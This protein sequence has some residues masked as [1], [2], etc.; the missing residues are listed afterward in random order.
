MSGSRLWKFKFA[1]WLVWPN[2]RSSILG[3]K[4]LLDER[5]SQIRVEKKTG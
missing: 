4:I 1:S 3:K 2:L 5:F